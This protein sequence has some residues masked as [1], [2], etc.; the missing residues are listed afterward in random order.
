MSKI[1]SRWADSS[2]Q[3]ISTS[4]DKTGIVRLLAVLIWL[5]IWQ[6]VS[7]CLDNRLLLVSP[8]NVFARLFSLATEPSFWQAVAFSL[9][10]IMGGFF[11]AF[12]ASVIAALLAHRF[13]A[14][15]ILLW[16]LV[17][18]IRSVPVASFIILALVWLP[19]AGLPQ[20]IAFLMVFPILYDSILQGLSAMS[21]EMEEV[22]EIFEIR[23]AFYLR[24]IVLPQLFPFVLGGC[25]SALGLVWKAGIAAEVIAM[26]K[27]SIGNRLQ[28]AK[29]YLDTPDLFAWTVVVVVL[30]IVCSRLV[31]GILKGLERL[32]I[33][34]SFAGEPEGRQ[35]AEDG[36]SIAKTGGAS[37]RI[38][39]IP[40][41]GAYGMKVFG[42]SKSYEDNAVLQDVTFAV[43]PAGKYA[44]LAPSGAGKTTLI[45]IL[46]GLE[47]ADSGQITVQQDSDNGRTD[48]SDRDG[49]ALTGC[50][51]Q[52]NR[53]IAELSAAG[54]I[55]LGNRELTFAQI[56]QAMERVGLKGCENKKAAALSGGMQRRV[57]LLRALL[58]DRKILCLDEPFKGLDE[59]TRVGALRFT[60]E[61]CK[62]RTLILV[63]HEESEARALDAEVIRL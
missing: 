32:L 19:S 37:D 61:M 45:R 8:L 22:A 42:I 27:G 15:R 30:S 49:G 46:L 28:Q 1:P 57:A 58:S 48:V 50:C 2:P 36:E 35:A 34:A 51:F 38:S 55:A 14:V 40:I 29:V 26:P 25:Q 54:N 62:D 5:V 20:L 43:E 17:A 23:G 39:D 12:P 63:T 16:P 18:C 3:R 7:V 53:L 31:L 4:N 44:I 56:S 33:Q 10:R 60:K 47:H 6:A 24:Y 59:E 9:L 21:T 11:L 52:E 13:S 41:G